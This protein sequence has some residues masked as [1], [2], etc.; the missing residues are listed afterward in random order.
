MSTDKERSATR[1]PVE[2]PL[3]HH[4]LAAE[5]TLVSHLRRAHPK[6]ELAAYIERSY[7]ETQ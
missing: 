3:C 5:V 2:C 4:S 6:R 7:E 1:L